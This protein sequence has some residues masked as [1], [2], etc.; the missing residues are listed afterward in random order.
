MHLVQYPAK[1]LINGCFYSF[2]HFVLLIPG[3]LL[4]A[5][6]G[7]LKTAR[8]M[9][10]VGESMWGAKKRAPHCPHAI[11]P[12]HYSWAI[13]LALTIQ[14]AKMRKKN[15]YLSD[16]CPEDWLPVLTR[17]LHPL[18]KVV[19]ILY[20]QIRKKI[21]VLGPNPQSLWL[22]RSGVGLRNF[23]FNKFA[24]VSDVGTVAHMWYM[25]HSPCSLPPGDNIHSLLISGHPTRP[26]ST[27]VMSAHVLIS[28]K[29]FITL[30]HF[31]IQ[32]EPD[33]RQT[34]PEAVISLWLFLWERQFC[35]QTA[36][37]LTCKIE[38]IPLE[39]KN[40]LKNFWPQT[41]FSKRMLWISIQVSKKGEAVYSVKLKYLKK[42]TQAIH[43]CMLVKTS[44]H[45]NKDR[46]KS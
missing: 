22:T 14:V 37:M 7:T 20:R 16:L 32:T 41:F 10:E 42:I 44:N 13:N 33:P 40:N 27:L 36:A 5:Q 45:T 28:K 34:E 18:R 29:R 24:G 46:I 1:C 31:T 15:L 43:V 38:R 3:R 25:L 12:H 2:I 8:G 4:L 26:A 35:W 19:L 9:K 30:S 17:P 23:L 11:K 39:T 6:M 21:Q